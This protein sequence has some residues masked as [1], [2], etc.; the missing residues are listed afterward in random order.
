MKSV[1]QDRKTQ[2]AF[3]DCQPK[4]PTNLKFY[5]TPEEYNFELLE[6]SKTYFPDLFVKL[7]LMAPNTQNIEKNIFKSAD[8]WIQKGYL[9]Q[10]DQRNTSNTYSTAQNTSALDYYLSGIK[11][12]PTNLGCAYNI[13]CS[14]YYEKMFSNSL[15][16]FKLAE[17]LSSEN[18]DI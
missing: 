10:N 8:Y 2:V 15:K 18:T 3:S 17:N 16:W 12:D 13:A 6:A 1:S 5:I 7:E 9:I 4:T 11:I 14:F